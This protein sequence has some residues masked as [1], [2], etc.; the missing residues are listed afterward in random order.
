[1]PTIEPGD[2]KL[3]NQPI[4]FYGLN[5]YS[6]DL[7]RTCKP[8]ASNPLG[9]DA[10]VE[11]VT[12][13]AGHPRTA[14]GWHVLPESLYYCPK[15]LYERY[16]VPMVI[17]ENGLSCLDWVSMDGKVHDPQRIDYTRRYLLQLKRAIDEGTKMLGYFHWSLMDN[18]EWQNGYRDRFGLIHIDFTTQKRTIKEAGHWYRKVIQTHGASLHD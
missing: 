15:W 10:T 11:E 6:A 13:P 4:D 18:M 14:I 8:Y 12:F 3:I 9:S 1:M 16:K 2:M 7:V 17:T 5:I